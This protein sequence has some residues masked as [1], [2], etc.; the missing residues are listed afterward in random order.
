MARKSVLHIRDLLYSKFSI[1]ELRLLTHSLRTFENIWGRATP[2][3]RAQPIVNTRC[4]PLMLPRCV[5]AGRSLRPRRLQQRLMNVC[6]PGTNEV[7]TA[8]RKRCVL[9]RG[10][11]RFRSFPVWLADRVQPP[12]IEM[13]SAAKQTRRRAQLHRAS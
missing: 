3:R 10:S 12:F 7:L 8:E 9:L 11:L 5:R 4:P 13:L 1:R 2:S 6:S